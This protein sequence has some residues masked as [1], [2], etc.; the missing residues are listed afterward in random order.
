[1]L[2][3]SVS[4]PTD[5]WL[6]PGMDGTGRLFA[7]LVRALDTSRLRPRVFAYDVRASSYDAL[8]ETLPR[9]SGP[10]IVLAESFGGPLAVRLARRDRELVKELVLVASFVRPPRP[11]LRAAAPLLRMLPP[12]PA[13]LIRASMLGL[14]AAP[15]LVDEVARAIRSTPRETLAGR[16]VAIADLDLRAHTLDCPVRAVV[17]QGDR[18]VPRACAEEPARLS[19]LGT[20]TTITGPHLLAQ[21]HPTRVVELLATNCSPHLGPDAGSRTTLTDLEKRACEDP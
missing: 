5:L 13:P 14:D 20:I 19:R 7:P 17:A 18:L 10:T 1:M 21:T 2:R 16:L 11:F 4:A 3:A 9:P 8:L 15:A 12:P 6:L